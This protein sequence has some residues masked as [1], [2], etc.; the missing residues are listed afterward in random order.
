MDKVC[1]THGKKWYAYR[2]LVGS[3]MERAHKEDLEVSWKIILKWIL[4]R[5]DDLVQDKDS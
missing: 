5:N 4:L 3:Q 2:M 1:S